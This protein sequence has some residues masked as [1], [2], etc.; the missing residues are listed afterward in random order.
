MSETIISVQNL[1]KTFGDHEVLRKIDMDIHVGEILNMG[2]FFILNILLNEYIFH[3]LNI[4]KNI[5]IMKI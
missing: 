3:N 1:N 4:R 2:L 5:N